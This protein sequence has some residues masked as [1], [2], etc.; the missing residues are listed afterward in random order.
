MASLLFEGGDFRMQNMELT[1]EEGRKEYTIFE[2]QGDRDDS[3]ESY[4]FTVLENEMNGSIDYDKKSGDF[5]VECGKSGEYIYVN[6]NLQSSN[7]GVELL[8]DEVGA[9]DYRLKM[10]LQVSVEKGA[11]FEKLSGENI[12]IGNMSERELGKVLL[13]NVYDT[14]W[15]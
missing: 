11:S 12:D 1:V 3:E 15:Y 14:E 8:V 4:D 10:K 7:S 13:E 5:S 2:W 6:G 9:N